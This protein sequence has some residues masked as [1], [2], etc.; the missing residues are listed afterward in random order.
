MTVRYAQIFAHLK[1]PPYHTHSDYY[2]L[3]IKFNILSHS[4]LYSFS[5]GFACITFLLHCVSDVNVSFEDVL[6]HVTKYFLAC[7]TL[8]RNRHI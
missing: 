1:I 3:A 2:G 7:F 8:N 4:E 6:K 5:F